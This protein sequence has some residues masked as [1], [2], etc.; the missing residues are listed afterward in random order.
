MPGPF[1]GMD[2]WLES[3]D[4][5]PDAHHGLIE[6]FRTQ[7]VSQVR[8]EYLVTIEKRVYLLDEDD[9]ALHLVVPDLLL[10]RG[11]PRPPPT[12]SAAAPAGGVTTPTASV[13]MAIE[14][15]EVREAR[16]VVRR[17]EERKV[18][19]VIE[20]LS[21]A[22]KRAGS[23]G[24]EQYLEQRREVLHSP[25]HLVEIDL[26]RAGAR[27]PNID[28]LPAAQYMALVSRAHERPRC[29]VWAW[30]SRSPAPTIPVPLAGDASAH[31]DLGA[32]IHDLYD[33]A[34]YEDLLEYAR[35]PEPPLDPEDAAWA[36]E[37]LKAR[38][39]IG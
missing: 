37:V 16:L 10:L 30:S 4:V 11:R 39:G 21:P 24:R 36:A 12:G 7:L 23:R 17:P 13:R 15:V 25:V 38:P 33:R 6:T 35:P 3:P 1:P 32:A 31:L 28:A 2:P 29:D 20:L 8:H 34:G 5:G 14:P 9:P 26:L 27:L 22:N 19:S 18:V